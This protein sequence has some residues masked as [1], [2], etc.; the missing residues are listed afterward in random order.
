MSILLV[1]IC[2]S[3]AIAA[4]VILRVSEWLE[5]KVNNKFPA[6]KINKK[7]GE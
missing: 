6:G 5:K 1:A 3:A 2:A 4:Y 7:K